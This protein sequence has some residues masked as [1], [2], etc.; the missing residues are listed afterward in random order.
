M[1]SRSYKYYEALAVRR[2]FEFRLTFKG[3]AYDEFIVDDI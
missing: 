1:T 2:K 3:L